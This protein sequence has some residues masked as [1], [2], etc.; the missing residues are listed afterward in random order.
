[1]IN[2]DS[3]VRPSIAADKSDVLLEI[4]DLNVHFSLKKSLFSTGGGRVVKAVNDVSLSIRKGEV[5]GVIGESGSGKS[6]LGRA[7]TGLAPVTSGEIRFDGQR[8]SRIS[9]RQMMPFR[10]HIQFV[11]Q[12]PH[13]SLNPTMTIGAAIGHPLQIHTGKSYVQCL[14]P[15][16]KIMKQV[17]LSP[18]ER[19]IDKFPSELSGGQKQRAVIARAII[20]RPQLLIA[21]EP[22][23]MLDMSVR[24]KILSL[25]MELKRDLDLTYV[26]I[27][28]DLASAR[29]FCDRIA[30]MY[31]GRIVEQGTTKEIF[32]DPKHPYTKALIAAMPHLSGSQSD[33]PALKGEVADAAKPPSGC[34]FHPRCPVAFAPCGWQADDLR[35]MLD[36]RS[37]T[38][39][40]ENVDAIAD[41][42]DGD[43]CILAKPSSSQSV[44]SLASTLKRLREDTPSD[45]LWTGISEIST[46]GQSVQLTCREP[47]EPR[48]VMLSSRHHVLCHLYDS[49]IS[50]TEPVRTQ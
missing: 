50:P 28:H 19:F 37:L 26:Y 12:D 11:F 35:A 13:A 3:H 45:P 46:N 20:T 31:M 25:M 14:E 24:A 36:A 4:S 22:I 44:V 32:Q 1:M 38:A 49:R 34:A 10:K 27:T 2:I 8:I 41:I 42:R 30:I 17:G 21:D 9:R 39:S 29:F 7:I 43:G 23:S 40:D 33:G 5:L 15:I 6:T 47:A 48:E 18:V 16:H